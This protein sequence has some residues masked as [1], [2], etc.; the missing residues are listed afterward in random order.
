MN[1]RKRFSFSLFFLFQLK[2]R[3]T[4]NY[5]RFYKTLPDSSIFCI[6]KWNTLLDFLIFEKTWNNLYFSFQKSC[7]EAFQS[8][9]PNLGQFTGGHQL[10]YIYVKSELCVNV[11]WISKNV[12]ENV[13]D[14][15]TNVFMEVFWNSQKNKYSK[16]LTMSPDI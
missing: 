2:P 9:F 8:C 10:I 7:L 3:I 13:L 6:Q 11:L 15:V 1:I 12:P 16:E 5:Q 14:S 4:K